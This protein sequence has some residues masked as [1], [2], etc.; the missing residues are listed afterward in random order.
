[1][2]RIMLADDH[3][4]VRAGFRMLLEQDSS[5]CVVAEAADGNQ[6]YEIAARE[7]PDIV[8]MDI[9]M[10]PGQT[11][12]IACERIAKD[13]LYTKVIILTMYAEVEYLT[14]TLSGGA[15]GYLLKNCSSQELIEAIHT[16]HQGGN[17]IHS[18]MIELQEQQN[19]N[20]VDKRQKTYQDLSSRELEVLLLIAKGFTNKEI[21]ERLYLSVKT[22][23]AHRAKVYAKLGLSTRS[24]LVAY[25][26]KCNLLNL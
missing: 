9:S 17:Y 2:I 8:L 18:K 4:I 7:K 3:E 22:V 13:F 24:D 11:G 10:P 21:S 15:A 12:L 23:E 20:Q 25:A 26:L 16:V 1:M 6:A 5:L 14:Y 19:N